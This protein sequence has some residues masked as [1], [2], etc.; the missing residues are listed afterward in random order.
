MM[1]TPFAT[2]RG[3]ALLVLALFASSHSHAQVTIDWSS[4]SSSGTMMSSSGSLEMVGTIGQAVSGPIGNGSTTLYGG[5][6]T[7]ELEPA[8]CPADYF[9]DG[10]I[11]GNDVEAFFHDWE[12]GVSG[13]DV[14]LDGGIDGADV[15]YFFEV[16]EAGGC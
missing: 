10:G 2:L 11:D 3:L 4:T 1:K 8:P 9:P 5:F 6:L 14:N 12:A 16:W 7:A 15:A 13:A